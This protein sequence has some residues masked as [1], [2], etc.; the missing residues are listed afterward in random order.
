MQLF[1][2]I[3]QEVGVVK[4]LRA[5]AGGAEI[6]ITAPR[7]TALLEI[8]DSVCTQGACLTC[9]SKDEDSFAADLSQETLDRTTFGRLRPG[10]P[11]NLE[12][13]L[14]LSDRLGGHLV[15]GHVDGVGRLEAEQT[16]GDGKTLTFSAPPNVM[17]YVI[18]KGSICVDG[19]SLTVAGLTDRTFWVALIPHT[20]EVT[21]LG[22]LR[23]GDPVNLEADL[24]GKYVEKLLG[25]NEQS[26]LWSALQKSGF[27]AAPPADSEGI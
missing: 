27:V 14:R 1:T 23:V 26:D 13:A 7:T 11:V 20:L 3:V 2:G 16:S 24:I 19:V 9:V 25:T 22:R 12:P 21:T 15:T 8:G 10:D 4:E 6:E 17:R 5:V 18:E